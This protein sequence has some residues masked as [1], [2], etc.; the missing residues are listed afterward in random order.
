MR[1]LLL[2]VLVLQLSACA[3]NKALQPP[4]D[5]SLRNEDDA[6]SIRKVALVTS[7]NP[8][9][10]EGV[11]RGV[12]HA[13]GAAKGALAGA[14]GGAMMGVSI[15]LS[16][17][18][19]AVSCGVALLLTPVLAVGGGVVG[20]VVGGVA[21]DSA[22]TLAASESQAQQVL[23]GEDLQSELLF[24]AQEYGQGHL[25]I[26]LVQAPTESAEDLSSEENRTAL[27]NESIDHVLS[28]ELLQVSLDRR[29]EMRARARLISVQTGAVLR[30]EEYAYFSESRGRE[31]W[32]AGN[33]QPLLEAIKRGLQALAEGA[34]DEQF[35]LY[36]T[37]EPEGET[38]ARG[39]QGD[40]RRKSL[41][42]QF[43]PHYALAPV[44]PDLEVAELSN[45]DVTS[46][47]LKFVVVD[48]PK[49]TFQWEAFPR[50][51]ELAAASNEGHQITDV[52]Y[53]LRVFDAVEPFNRDRLFVPG[54]KVYEA[55][56]I[57]E[58]S[59]TIEEFLPACSDYYWTVRAKFDL[60]G[61]TRATE[62]AGVYGVGGQ[63]S[64]W[65]LRGKNADRHEPTSAEQLYYPF[66][67]ACD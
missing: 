24:R 9:E 43:V 15:A 32:M 62:W 11:T 60:D 6:G 26:E 34:V 55:R 33:A 5:A 46:W 25:D 39:I 27:A 16:A 12:T 42:S 38:T 52:R 48:A 65:N 40:D 59:H 56:D 58:P 61:Q 31:G 8:P 3:T 7:P 66:K 64:P 35:L 54:L 10:I 63:Y 17:C 20:G 28:L 50:E 36:Y 13:K 30:D 19:E 18:V 51:F 4:H 29:L 41:I 53:E 21:G 45:D 2:L 44:I 47:H 57:R 37:A 67:L 22:D 1:S 23:G 14:A 49:P